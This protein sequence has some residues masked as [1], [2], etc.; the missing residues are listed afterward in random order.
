MRK[1]K[2]SKHLPSH[3]AALVGATALVSYAFRERLHPR[4]NGPTRFESHKIRQATNREA[5][6]QRSHRSRSS[7][8]Q[9]QGLYLQGT[10]SCITVVARPGCVFASGSFIAC[11]YYYPG[12]IVLRRR[13]RRSVSVAGL[14]LSSEL[15]WPGLF[16]TDHIY[17]QYGS[18]VQIC[19][20]SSHLA[21]IVLPLGRDS[22]L[23]ATPPVQRPAT[24]QLLST[25]AV[26]ERM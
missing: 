19:S 14:P 5:H 4:V 26:L 22:E 2:I 24:C 8:T 20:C 25:L 13:R 17:R 21:G 11:C 12:R 15:D 23:P 1:V 7:L 3:F 6:E 18:A 9:L 10:F 16:G